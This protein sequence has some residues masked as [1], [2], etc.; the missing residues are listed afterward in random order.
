MKP[1]L[2]RLLEHLE[3]MAKAAV[4]PSGSRIQ[5]LTEMSS[6]A[7]IGYIRAWITANLP[8]STG[9]G[10]MPLPEPPAGKEEA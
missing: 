1:P 2:Q 3:E 7:T 8:E 5:T 6:L 9:D 4:K 10:W